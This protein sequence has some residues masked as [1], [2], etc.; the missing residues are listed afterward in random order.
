MILPQRLAL[1]VAALSVAGAEFRGEITDAATGKP[2]AARVYIQGADGTWQFA[3]SADAAGAAVRYDRRRPEF[4]SFEVHT[5]LSAHPF[6][7]DLPPGKYTVTIE[8]GKEYHTLERAITVGADTVK[9]S[10]Q[11]RRWITLADRGWYS[12]DTHV[13][14]TLEETPTAMMAED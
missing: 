9:E 7:A 3:K 14:R 12:G 8:R 2:V 11:L 10:F 6:V 1:A 5:S 4:K 13:H